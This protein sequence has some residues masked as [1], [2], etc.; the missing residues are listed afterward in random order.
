MKRLIFIITIFFSCLISIAQP[1]NDLCSGAI[2][3]GTLGSPGACGSGFINGAITTVATTNLLAT[4]EN[5]YLSL[6]GCGMASGPGVCSVWYTFVAPTNGYGVNIVI[7]GGGA[8]LANPNIALWNGTGGCAGLA[9]TSCTVG[10]GGTATLNVPSGIVPG[11]TYYIQISGNV[12]QSGNFNLSLNAFLDCNDCLTAS[13]LTVSPLPVSGSYQ[14]GQTVSF[15]YHIDRWKQVTNNWLHGVQPTFGSGW[16]LTTIVPTS[17]PT[18]LSNTT[19]NIPA[20]VLSTPSCGYWSY[21]PAGIISNIGGVAWPPGF[22]FNGTYNSTILGVTTCGS[23][24]DGNPGNNFGD[25]YSS[26][27]AIINPPAGQ[28]VFCISIQVKNACLPGASLAVTWGTS[29]DGESGAFADP[30]C[31]SDPLT[32]F[33]AIIACCPPIMTST[34]VACFSGSTGIASAAPIGAAGPYTYNWIGP[35]GY[36]NNQVGVAGPSTITGLVAGIYTLTTIDATLCSKTTTVS[37]TQPAVL[38]ATVVP[39]N[40]TCSMSG[41]ITTT[42]AG[43]TPTYTYSWT[44]PLGFTSI[45]QNPIG[46]AAGIF[47][48]VMLDSKLCSITKTV[49]ITSPIIPTITATSNATICPGTPVTFSATGGVSYTWSPGATLNTTLGGT[50]IATPTISTI[51][52]VTGQNASG[53]SSTATVSVFVGG[54][55]SLTISPTATVCPNQAITFTVIGATNYTWTPTTFLSNSTTGTV[56]VTPT[57]NTTYTVIGAS[58]TCTGSTQVSI[59]VSNTVVVTASTNSAIICPLGSAILSANGATNYTWSPSISLSSSVGSTV[60]ASP[61]TTTT[62]NVIGATSTCTNS[63]FVVVTLTTSPIIS[64]ASATICSGSNTLLTAIGA[65]TYS[66]SPSITLSASSGA[67]VTASPVI[68]TLYTINGASSLGCLASTTVAVIVVPTPTISALAS[69]A[70]ICLGDVSNLSAFGATNYTWSPGGASLSTTT[71]SPITTTNYTVIGTN[72]IGVFTCTSSQ[73][74]MVTITPQTTVI[75]SASQ[76]LCLGKSTFIFATGGDTYSWLPTSGVL[77]P[78]SSST[79]ITPSVT[80]IYTV[81]A[82]NGG[83]C[84]S[85]AT[86]QIFVNPIPFVYAGVDTTINIDESYILHGTGNVMVGFLSPDSIPLICNYCSVVEVNPKEYTCYK[87]R[88]ENEFGCEAFDDICIKITKDWN[89]YIPNAFTPNGDIDNEIFIPVGYGLAEIKLFIFDRWGVQI[90]KS[91][92]EVIGWD[93]KNKGKLCEQDVYVYQADIKTI[94]GKKIKRIGHVTLLPRVH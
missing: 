44:G 24:L 66:W 72:N 53:C 51:Y 36:V 1:V 60:T 63:A 82:S 30:G 9:G 67:M 92:G 65:N 83:L 16:D 25:G 52:T 19:Y 37:V 73:N 56:V 57:A 43:G 68:T 10:A 23:D 94:S 85:T 27:G 74:V 55:I 22:Y 78:T 31:A 6:V 75:A 29:G 61:V 84:S 12:G 5:P 69:P 8:P 11:N 89:I 46:L 80:T 70:S 41:S 39:T 26:P 81:T 13:S 59:V 50:V 77:N 28:W 91:Q 3:L 54:S 14:P 20:S 2:S 86:L 34:M 7:S 79:Q 38:S 18:Y 40:G 42:P 87:L 88:G 35:G 64:S 33:N 17:P 58:G 4:A 90:F 76:T 71:V 32:S 21:Y 15:C 62:Y 93:G 47:T 48:L 49:S 45:S